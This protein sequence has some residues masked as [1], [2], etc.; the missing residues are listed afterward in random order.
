MSDN[1]MLS[2]EARGRYRVS[3]H[4]QLEEQIIRYLQVRTV[5]VPWQI[6]AE[7]YGTPF[8]RDVLAYVERVLQEMARE[9]TLEVLSAAGT[10]SYTLS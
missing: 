4:P 7:V 2:R 5:A 1:T 6:V 8:D 9:G 3:S 10:P